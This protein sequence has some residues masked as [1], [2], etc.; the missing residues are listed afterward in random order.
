MFMKAKWINDFEYL[1]FVY[2]GS[3]KM[4][5]YKVIYNNIHQGHNGCDGFIATVSL[6]GIT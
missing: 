6:Q 5:K 2:N 4:P 3:E 1:D